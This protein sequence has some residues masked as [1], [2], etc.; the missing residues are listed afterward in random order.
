MEDNAKILGVLSDRSPFESTPAT[1]RNVMNGVNAE[2]GVS[3]D[4]A[5]SIGKKII[6]SM[7]G[8]SVTEYSFERSSK[9]VTLGVASSV[10]I[11]NEQVQVDPKLLFQ[12]LVL[13]CST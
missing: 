5:K 4:T 7:V 13:A 2:E 8:Q 10:R 11:G 6:Q 1:L 3:V 9:A 12:R